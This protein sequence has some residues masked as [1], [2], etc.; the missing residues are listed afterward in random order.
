MLSCEPSRP[1]TVA[2]GFALRNLFPVDR[3]IADSPPAQLLQI[4]ELL[5]KRLD[6]LGELCWLEPNFSTNKASTIHLSLR[7]NCGQ[8]A[9]ASVSGARPRQL[10]CL[11]SS[12][13]GA[14]PSVNSAGPFVWSRPAAPCGRLR[15][16]PRR[17]NR[18]RASDF[19]RS[20][21][22]PLSC[23]LWRS[24]DGRHVPPCTRVAASV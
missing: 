10:R 6:K 3:Q 21:R 13:G 2:A 4:P 5:R 8:S 14:M 11:G 16:E 20:Q 17:G 18:K 7:G 23:D 1:T 15:I 12:P 19:P 22:F 24:R 9:T